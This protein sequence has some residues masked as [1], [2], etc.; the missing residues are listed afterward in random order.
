MAESAAIR[1]LRR[2]ERDEG[3]HGAYPGPGQQ[4]T[5]GDRFHPSGTFPR[6]IALATEEWPACANS[7][8]SACQHEGDRRLLTRR[9]Q[10]IGDAAITA[11]RVLVAVQ[12][13][14]IRDGIAPEAVRFE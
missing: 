8:R 12:S 2:P 4:A 13:I 14:L 6:A 5:R 7:R 1:P 11:I 10:W 3:I 9:H